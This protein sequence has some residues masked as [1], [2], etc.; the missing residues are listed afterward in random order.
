MVT[1]TLSRGYKNGLTL[2]SSVVIDPT[3]HEAIKNAVKTRGGI[4]GAIHRA[5]G[6]NEFLMFGYG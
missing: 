1:G 4:D 3:D 5:A 6:L 2:D